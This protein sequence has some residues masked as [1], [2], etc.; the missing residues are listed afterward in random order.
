MALRQ[1]NLIV[2]AVFS[3][4][5]SIANAVRTCSEC[6]NKNQE[7]GS[8]FLLFFLFFFFRSPPEKSTRKENDSLAGQF[9]LMLPGF[10]HLFFLNLFISIFVCGALETTRQ[11]SRI[12]ASLPFNDRRLRFSFVFFLFLFLVLYRILHRFR[13]TLFAFT[14][15]LCLDSRRP[16]WRHFLFSLFLSFLLFFFFLDFL[17]RTFESRAGL[18]RFDGFLWVFP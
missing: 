17:S 11:L 15:S 14:S 12:N 9:F 1:A 13:R 18:E 10:V 2:D 4:W 5:R 3:R 6:P 16:S 7:A 8:Y